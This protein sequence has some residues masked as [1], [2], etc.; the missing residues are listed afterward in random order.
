MF[1]FVGKLSTGGQKTFVYLEEVR[2]E[3]VRQHFEGPP[4]AGAYEC[5][6]VDQVRTANF[7]RVDNKNWGRGYE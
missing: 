3:A 6:Y 4:D 2:I 5:Q 7:P 1:H